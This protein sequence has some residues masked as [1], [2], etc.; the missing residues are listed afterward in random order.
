MYLD[1]KITTWERVF[2]P[3]ELKEEVLR[4]LKD[5]KIKTA[6]DACNIEKI[7]F[8]GTIDGTEVQL[9]PKEND[10]FRTIDFIDDDGEKSLFKNGI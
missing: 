1:F 2:V 7:Y 4:L 6:N 5:G 10:G 3:D 9:V 8:E